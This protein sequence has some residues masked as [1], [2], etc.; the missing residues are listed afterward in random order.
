M[1]GHRGAL[2]GRAI[3]LMQLQRFDEAETALTNLINRLGSVLGS[4][5]ATGIGV[6]AAAHANRGILHDRA[7]RH[8]KALA[9]YRIALRIDREAVAGPGVVD[10]IL[11]NTPRPATVKNRA[12]YL[13]RQ[14]A[15]PVDQRLLRVPEIDDR[16]RMHKP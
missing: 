13:Q 9:D 10:K 3:A 15:L 1:P 2:M 7:G 8:E 4:D 5:D 16:Q 14:L 11:R 12:A 6:L